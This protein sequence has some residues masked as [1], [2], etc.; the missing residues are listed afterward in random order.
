MR[1]DVDEAK[2]DR[3]RTLQ[4]R[5]LSPLLPP[6][7]GEMEKEFEQEM[8]KYTDASQDQTN[9]LESIYDSKA[10]SP[11]SEQERAHVQDQQHHVAHA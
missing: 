3:R 1:G 5:N 6:S 7:F 11:A 9:I 2:E 8:L 10:H 4:V